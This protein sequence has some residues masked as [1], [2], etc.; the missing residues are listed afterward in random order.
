LAQPALIVNEME[1]QPE[2]TARQQE[3][4]RS[5]VSRGDEPMPTLRFNVGDY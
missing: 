5:D 4:G 2:L 3:A 1:S